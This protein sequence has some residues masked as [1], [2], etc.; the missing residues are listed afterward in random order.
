MDNNGRGYI[1]VC[2]CIRHLSS[3]VKDRSGQSGDGGG[4]GGATG[5]GRSEGDGG[6]L[7]FFGSKRWTIQAITAIVLTAARIHPHQETGGAEGGAE[8]GGEGGEWGSDM[9]PHSL[10][11]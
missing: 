8:G 2:S 1:Q 9:L 5:G 11:V 6:G 7:G 10:S 4:A 3:E